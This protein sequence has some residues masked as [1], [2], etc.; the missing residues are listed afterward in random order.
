MMELK[1]ICKAYGEKQV[2]QNVDLTLPEGGIIA[3]MGASGRG[4][5][6]LLRI[7]TGELTADKGSIFIPQGRRIGYISQLADVPEGAL[8]EDV[9]RMAF[10]DIQRVSAEIEE[11]QIEDPAIRKNWNREVVYRVLLTTDKT[12]KYK[13]E[14][15]I[16]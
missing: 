14:F 12:K 9:L 1:G 15:I 11:I 10:A 6:T 7:M 16:Q 5:T 2:L 8:V 3:L 13:F 4:K